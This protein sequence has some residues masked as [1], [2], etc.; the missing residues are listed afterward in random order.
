MRVFIT[1][2]TGLVGSRLVP[3]LRQRGDAVLVLSRRANA[4]SGM[5]CEMI[6]GDPTQPGDWQGD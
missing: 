6:Q 5:D 2:G 1:G 4:V 3:H